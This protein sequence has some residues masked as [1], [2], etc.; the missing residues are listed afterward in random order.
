[1]RKEFPL[2][3]ANFNPFCELIGLD[4]EQ[5]NS[6]FSRSVIEVKSHLLNPNRVVHGGVIYAMAD[7]GMGA[8]IYCSL[9]EG[10]NCATIEIKISYLRPIFDGKIICDAKLLQKGRSIGVL[11][12][13]IFNHDR[14]VA[15]A[16]GTFSI[17][18]E[19]DR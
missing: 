3:S 17:H 19:R 10:E 1:M 2:K 12:A 13:E 14:L 15:K 18:K 11:E 5:L 4:F 9:T 16:L 7:T 6:Q 8:V